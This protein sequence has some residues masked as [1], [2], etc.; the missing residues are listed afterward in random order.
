VAEVARDPV[1][2]P[3]DFRLAGDRLPLPPGTIRDHRRDAQKENSG[4]SPACFNLVGLPVLLLA[5]VRNDRHGCRLK[6]F[7]FM[8][9]NDV[10]TRTLSL[11]DSVFVTQCPILNSDSPR[12]LLA[13]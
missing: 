11:H 4:Q 1:P 2:A 10:I 7:F 6:S 3:L 8:L 13:R 12:S 9:V 5:S